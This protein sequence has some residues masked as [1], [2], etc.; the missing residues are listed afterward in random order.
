MSIKDT[1]LQKSIMTIVKQLDRDDK[2]SLIT[3]S[4]IDTTIF[5]SLS[6]ED[7][8]DIILS[9]SRINI[10]GCTCG[11]EGLNR[12]YQI[13]TDNFIEN[14]NNRVIIITDGDFNFG[15]YN[16]SE[17]KQFIREKKNLMCFY[18]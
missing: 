16:E 10:S 9:L 12:A 14:G 3:Y 7:I 15:T 17:L 6:G 13:A 11:S 1:T 18:Q 8:A 5:R 4:D 2:I